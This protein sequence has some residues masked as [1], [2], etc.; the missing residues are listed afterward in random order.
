MTQLMNINRVCRAAPG[1]ASGSANNRQQSGPDLDDSGRLEI[2]LQNMPLYEPLINPSQRTY[3]QFLTL[4]F[5]LGIVFGKYL[6]L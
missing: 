5:P 1:K 4:L 3:A 6:V 2:N